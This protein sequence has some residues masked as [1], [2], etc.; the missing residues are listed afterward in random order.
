MRRTVQLLG[1]AS[2]PT[3]GRWQRGAD[4]GALYLADE[5]DTAVAE[6][7]LYLAERGLRLEEQD[8]PWIV[9]I[10]LARRLISPKVAR[11]PPG[12]SFGCSFCPDKPSTTGSNRGTARAARTAGMALQ[13]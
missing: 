10:V 3:D 1:R 6:R 5:R 13:P 2:T 8:E 4:V 7:Y 9:G 11:C 12:C